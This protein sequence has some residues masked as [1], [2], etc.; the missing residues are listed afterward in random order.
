MITI[1]TEDGQT[2][3]VETDANIEI[4]NLKALLEADC[5]VP[6]ESQDLFYNARPL[7]DP[8]RTL[9]SFGVANDDLILLKDRR[10]LSQSVAHDSDSM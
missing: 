2:Y 7:D 1:A 8:K 6:P 3:A 4:E 9:A 10:R 5:G